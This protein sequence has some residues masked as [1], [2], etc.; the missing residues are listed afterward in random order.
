MTVGRIVVKAPS[1]PL[2]LARHEELAEQIQPSR[3]VGFRNHDEPF[4]SDRRYAP[5]N[6]HYP[7][8]ELWRKRDARHDAQS[9]PRSHSSWPSDAQQDVLGV[10]PDSP[11]PKQLTVGVQGDRLVLQRAADT[12]AQYDV[13]AG[14]VT[15]KLKN[16][17]CTASAGPCSPRLRFG[18]SAVVANSLAQHEITFG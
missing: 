10:W 17:F 7:V 16:E 5:V 13:Q 1:L 2:S 12:Q 8:P 6:L 11:L 15:R 14:R 9:L 18:P 4:K 3:E